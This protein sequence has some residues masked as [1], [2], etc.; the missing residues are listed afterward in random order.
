MARQSRVIPDGPIGPVSLSHPCWCD[1]PDLPV[2]HK[3]GA[4]PVGD[5]RRPLRTKP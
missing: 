5:P 1:R 4:H 2:E 3:L